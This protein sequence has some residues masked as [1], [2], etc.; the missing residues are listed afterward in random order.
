MFAVDQFTKHA[1][2][3]TFLPGESR[4]AIPHLLK[5]TFEENQRGA[6]GL[7]GNQPWLLIAM[8]LVVLALFWYSFRDI[9]RK[10]MLVRIAFGMI[11]GGAIGNIVDRLHFHYV[12][13]F[14]DFYSIWPNVF[15]I[16]D[17]CITVGVALLILSSL[18]PHR[19]T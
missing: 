16:A 18:A 14:I 4:I 10:S 9:A 17:S 2:A 5:W 1:V 19:S 13:D 7:F 12:V 15:N 6:F 3:T 11:T 8:A